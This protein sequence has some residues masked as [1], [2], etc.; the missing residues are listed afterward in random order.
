MLNEE[1]IQKLIDEID[2]EIETLMKNKKY[3]QQI[4]MRMENKTFK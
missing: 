3:L 2:S 1:L 4:L